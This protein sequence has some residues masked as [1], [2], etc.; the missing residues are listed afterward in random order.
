[1]TF[2]LIFKYFPWPLLNQ[3]LQIA[4]IESRIGAILIAS[5]DPQIPML[6]TKIATMIALAEKRQVKA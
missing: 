3:L 2:N 5:I 4:G 6:R 1:M